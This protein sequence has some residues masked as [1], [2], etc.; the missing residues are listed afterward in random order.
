MLPG[1]IQFQDSLRRDYEFRPLTGEVE[2]GLAEAVARARDLPGQVTLALQAALA[3]VGGRLPDAGVIDGLSVGDRQFLMTRLASVLGMGQVWLTASC[4]HCG[5]S[6]D[7]PL[8]YEQLPVKPAGNGFP[9]AHISTDQGMLTLR[10]PN[11]MDQRAVL[12]IADLQL[13]RQTLA[14]RCVSA[15]EGGDLSSLELDA[16]QVAAIEAALESVAP[17]I[18]TEVMAPCPECGASNR[19]SIDPYLCLGRVS[20]DLF[21]DIHRLASHYHWSEAE[22]LAMPRWRRQRYLALIDRSRGMMQ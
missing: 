14:K 17:E 2:M 13:A 18:A 5:E 3:H 19:V 12:G 10:V 6:F 4:R 1:G 9:D 22:I 21:A 7:F 11:G 20:Q 16:G 15:W 8:N